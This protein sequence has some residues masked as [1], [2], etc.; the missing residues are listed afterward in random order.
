MKKPYDKI[1]KLHNGLILEENQT[2]CLSDLYDALGNAWHNHV[3]FNEFK[4]WVFGGSVFLFDRNDTEIELSFGIEN[5]N[6]DDPDY[7]DVRI[8]TFEFKSDN[9]RNPYGSYHFNAL[10]TLEAGQTCA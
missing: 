1:V 3:S 8:T 4:E 6:Q 2:W 10:P 7:S 9:L 5:L